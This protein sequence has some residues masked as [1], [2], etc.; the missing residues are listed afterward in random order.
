M[1]IFS[2]K[3]VMADTMSCGTDSISSGDYKYKV[4]ALC[5]EPF[6]KEVVGLEE[7]TLTSERSKSKGVIT[8]G[9]QSPDSLESSESSS[10]AEYIE[11]WFYETDEGGNIRVLTFKGGK[12]V[13]IEEEEGY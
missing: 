8:Y 9:E 13:Y 2:V 10:H 6:H 12:L 1:V 4:K 7:K 5:G 11:K 3:S